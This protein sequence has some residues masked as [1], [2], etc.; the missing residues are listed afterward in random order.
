MYSNQKLITARPGSLYQTSSFVFD[1]NKGYLQARGRLSYQVSTFS[2]NPSFTRQPVNLKNNQFRNNIT[3]PPNTFPPSTISLYRNNKL[4]Y[5][6]NEGEKLC[7]T[8]DCSCAVAVSFK[9]RNVSFQR[10]SA[11]SSGS[12]TRRKAR[13]SKTRNQYNITNKWGIKSG[14]DSVFTNCL[15]HRV[16]PRG[17]FNCQFNQKYKIL[18]KYL[19]Q[20][21]TGLL[22]F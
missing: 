22:C 9:P 12:N 17:K 11:V 1:S 7:Y 18:F 4:V 6:S 2:Y 3:I 21:V 5:Y 16:T 8:T 19:H 13:I 20:I 14:G 10:D 15:Y